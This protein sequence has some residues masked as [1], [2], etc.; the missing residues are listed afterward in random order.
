MD[1]PIWPYSYLPDEVVHQEKLDCDWTI[2]FLK[3]DEIWY[4]DRWGFLFRLLEEQLK[5][6]ANTVNPEVQN[7]VRCVDSAIKNFRQ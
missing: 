5:W 4:A 7:I 2:F 3:N 1:L 6:S